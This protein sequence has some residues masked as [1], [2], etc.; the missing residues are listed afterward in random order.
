MIVLAM[1]L[2]TD[3]MEREK[4]DPVGAI[5]VPLIV[6]LSIQRKDKREE[7]VSGVMERRVI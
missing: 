1:F 7:S 2:S 3:R 4:E 6:L 5:L